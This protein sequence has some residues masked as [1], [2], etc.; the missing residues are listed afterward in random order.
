MESPIL[1]FLVFILILSIV[2]GY[3]AIPKGP[4]P[5]RTLFV[6][7]GNVISGIVLLGALLVAGLAEGGKNDFAALL[8]G[9]AVAFATTH[10]AGGFFSANR[11]LNMFREKEKNKL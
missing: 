11:M 5:L 2:V 7:G 6:S 1:V 3:E 4:S 10:V 8:G 9:L